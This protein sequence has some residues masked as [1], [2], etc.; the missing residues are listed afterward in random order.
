ME[1]IRFRK[2]C[3]FI[4]SGIFAVGQL[5]CFYEIG[6]IAIREVSP[7]SAKGVHC[8][9]KRAFVYLLF[10]LTKHVDSYEIVLL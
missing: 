6:L 9:R 10:Q 2:N 8:A 3:D 7:P 5:V 4:A 1:L